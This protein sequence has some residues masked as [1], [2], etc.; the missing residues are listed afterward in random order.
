VHG[1]VEHVGHAEHLPA[2]DR[3]VGAALEVM[4]RRN[5]GLHRRS[6]EEDQVGDLPSLQRQLLDPFVLDHRADAGALHVDQRRRRRDRDRFF[7]AADPQST[8]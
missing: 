1:A 2:G 5:A 4:R 7:E 3:D 6:R 8:D